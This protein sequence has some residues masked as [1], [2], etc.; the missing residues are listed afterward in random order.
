MDLQDKMPPIIRRTTSGDS[1][2]E[3]E[4]L[5]GEMMALDVTVAPE[6][7]PPRVKIKKSRTEGELG[8][9]TIARY[10]FVEILNNSI[11]GTLSPAS[12]VDEFGKQ[13]DA[14]KVKFKEVNDLIQKIKDTR[15]KYYQDFFKEIWN[16]KLTLEDMLG[17]G[18]LT[19]LIDIGMTGG[20]AMKLMRALQ[21][22]AGRHSYANPPAGRSGQ[23]AKTTSMS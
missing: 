5:H 23:I 9:L 20:W 12:P 22:G 18:G 7:I 21:K 17:Q 19:F 11:A 10:D 14:D 1:V 4:P 15:V 8:K 16:Q 3:E 2:I 6:A 13:S